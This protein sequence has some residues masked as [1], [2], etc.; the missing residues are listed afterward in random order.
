MRI[1]WMAILLFAFLASFGA[2]QELGPGAPGPAPPGI[3]PSSPGIAPALPPPRPEVQD[4]H[5]VK[6]EILKVERGVYLIRD[7]NGKQVRLPIGK[8]TKLDMAAYMV[9]DEV[10]AQMTSAGDVVSLTLKKP[11]SKRFTNP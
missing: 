1:G 11:V 6:G 3:A 2:T 4:L 7:S 5:S 10:E 9:G 8:E